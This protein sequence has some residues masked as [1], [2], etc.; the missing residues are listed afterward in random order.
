[1]KKKASD[2]L[3]RALAVTTTQFPPVL[4]DHALHISGVDRELQPDQAIASDDLLEQVLNALKKAEAVV[5]VKIEA[6]KS[7]FRVHQRATLSSCCGLALAQ[8]AD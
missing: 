6:C 7:G 1:M 4:I 5:E 2:A 8:L 3:R